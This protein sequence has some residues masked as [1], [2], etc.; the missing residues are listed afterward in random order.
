MKK[1]LGIVVAGVFALAFLSGAFV[2]DSQAETVPLCW[3]AGE[4]N[5]TSGL[6]YTCC[7]LRNGSG[8]PYI[9]CWW[10]DQ[11]FDQWCM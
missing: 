5:Y 2:V 1:L 7:E 10:D 11:Y 9:K 8:E 3:K 6:V 4:C